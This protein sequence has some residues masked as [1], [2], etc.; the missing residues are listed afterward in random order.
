MSAG[1]FFFFR[2]TGLEGIGK[3]Q[4]D[5]PDVLLAVAV[6]KVG[7]A[8]LPGTGVHQVGD[9][10]QPEADAE[11][12]VDLVDAVDVELQQSVIGGQI[13]TFVIVGVVPVRAGDGLLVPPQ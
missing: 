7:V 2:R 13:D 12:V 8:V 6:P 9:V 10:A 3:G 4:V 11:V 5:V 1:P